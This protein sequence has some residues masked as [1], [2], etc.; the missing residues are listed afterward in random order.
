MKTWTE[1]KH[2]Y[3]LF[4]DPM[5]SLYIEYDAFVDTYA[6]LLET[7]DGSDMTSYLDFFMEPS[8]LNHSTAV[9]KD[10]D[11]RLDFRDLAIEMKLLPEVR[12]V[13]EGEDKV[14]KDVRQAPKVQEK[15]ALADKVLSRQLQIERTIAKLTAQLAMNPSPA[16]EEKLARTKALL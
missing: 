7:L 9:F 10:E 16:L 12:E 11:A 1:S 13:M 8:P 14:D 4:E 6:P 5:Y 3:T 2:L 15:P